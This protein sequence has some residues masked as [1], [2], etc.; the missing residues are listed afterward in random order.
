MVLPA[1]S[2]K[3]CLFCDQHVHSANLLLRKHLRSQIC[4]NCGSEP[5]AV[6]CVTDNL[7]LCQE[8][9]WDAHGSCS[10]SS[11]HERTP[12]EGFSGCPSVLELASAWGLDDRT[13]LDGSG[14]DGGR[15]RSG[16]AVV[17]RKGLPVTKKKAQ[18]LGLSLGFLEQRF[19]K[20]ASSERTFDDE[21]EGTSSGS[22]SGFSRT[23][24][25]QNSIIGKDFQR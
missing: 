18:A 4:D 21:E 20:I 17:K 23:M 7:V 3:L 2:A 24:I 12:V 13:S 9:D 14:F 5:V 8:C 25:R 1:D 10:V 19:D 22:F 11:A 15:P 6:R 16:F